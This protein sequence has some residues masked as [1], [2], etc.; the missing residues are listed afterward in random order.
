MK[1]KKCGSKSRGSGEVAVN[2]SLLK[3]QESVVTDDLLKLK[4]H[5]RHTEKRLTPIVSFMNLL[6]CSK[7]GW[8]PPSYRPPVITCCLE[9]VRFRQLVLHFLMCSRLQ[10]YNF[11]TSP[12]PSSLSITPSHSYSSRGHCVPINNKYHTDSIFSTCRTLASIVSRALFAS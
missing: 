5:K 6:A 12:S 10:V 2:Q 7:F 8:W 3:R 9:L 4:R 11:S 1:L